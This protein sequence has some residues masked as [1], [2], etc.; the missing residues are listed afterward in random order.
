MGW[1]DYGIMGLWDDAI[2]NFITTFW[3]ARNIIKFMPR[4]FSAMLFL[5][6]AHQKAQQNK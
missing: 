3:Y 5:T 2:Y 4:H 1:W 6:M